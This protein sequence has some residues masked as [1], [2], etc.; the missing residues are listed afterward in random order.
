[1]AEAKLDKSLEVSRIILIRATPATVWHA[2]T[3]REMIPEY[4]FVTEALAHAKG[5]WT[6][7]LDNLKKL[8]EQG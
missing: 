2:L 3:D 7:V 1:M 8:L 6:M 4:F 5:G